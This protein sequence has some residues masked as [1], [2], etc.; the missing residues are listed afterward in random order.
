MSSDFERL[1]REARTTLPQPDESATERARVGALGAIRRHRNLRRPAVAILAAALVALGAGVGALV[2]PSGSAAPAP[3]GLGFLPERG[4]SVLQNGGDGTAVF[5]ATAVAANVPLSPEDDP[6]GL[7]LSTLKSLP[8]NGV[9]VIATFIARNAQPWLDAG[10]PT[11]RLPLE[12]HAAEPF[13]IQVRPERPLGEYALRASINGH[14]VDVNI[15]YGMRIPSP[16]LLAAAQQQLNRLVVRP[17]HAK[18]AAPAGTAQP[19]RSV[20]PA[21]ATATVFDRTFACLP[22]YGSV[23]MR[24]SPHGSIEVIG[25]TFISSGYM[26][27]TAGSNGELLSDLAS[28]AL[29]GKRTASTRFPAATYVNS[30]RCVASRAFVP[31]TH[32]ALPGPAATYLTSDEC[33]VAGKVLLR[34]HAVLRTPATWGRVGTGFVGVRGRLRDAVLAVRDRATGKPLAFAKLDSAG[35]TQLWTSAQCG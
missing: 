14:N 28:I 16:A 7:P 26:R 23:D 21:T 33:A 29:P 3:L 31:L 32:A 35:K 4:W 18:P 22:P 6:D 12:A 27:M 9:V 17:V 13:G 1:L 34:V 19:H 15:Y 11:R 2:A 20:S 25:A 8:P 10:Y 30:R 5:P 24:A